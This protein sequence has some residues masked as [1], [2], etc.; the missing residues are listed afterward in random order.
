[1]ARRYQHNL[2]ELK[3]LILQTAEVIVIKKG[4]H[5]LNARLIAMDIGY[6]VGSIYMV[7]DS[8]ADLVLHLNVRALNNLV[9]F[10]EQRQILKQDVT[11]DA[12]IKSYCD[13][14]KNNTNL[15][16]LLFEYQSHNKTNGLPAW[17]LD[18][19]E[20]AFVRIVAI[21]QAYLPPLAGTDQILMIKTFWAGLH[22]ILLLSYSGQIGSA[23]QQNTQDACIQV[24]VEKLLN[25]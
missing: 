20:Y 3:I 13:Y 7:F 16:R 24:L 2:Q 17:Y 1:M 15:W 18:E 11:I 4:F 5:G 12:L 9:S 8:M 10:L 23:Y 6:T 22:G 14:I 21:F 19:L 25:C